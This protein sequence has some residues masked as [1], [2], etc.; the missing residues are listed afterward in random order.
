M[1]SYEKPRA[2]K[3]THLR[4]NPKE[5]PPAGENPGQV[6]RQ[7]GVCTI[8][9]SSQGHRPY[10]IVVQPDA[11]SFGSSLAHA[12][13]AEAAGQELQPHRSKK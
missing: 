13:Q 1:P 12:S 6:L 2:V 8:A 3:P 7:A 9:S 11:L 10:L 5:E 4:A